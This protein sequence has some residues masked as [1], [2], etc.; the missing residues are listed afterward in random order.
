MC[1][2]KHPCIYAE[3]SIAQSRITLRAVEQY[4]GLGAWSS[5]GQTGTAWHLRSCNVLIMERDGG[6]SFEQ[7]TRRLDLPCLQPVELHYSPLQ[8]QFFNCRVLLIN[9]FFITVGWKSVRIL[10]AVKS[11][12]AQLW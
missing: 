10:R 1:W 5:G 11:E 8:F 4:A 2:E 6:R 3:M 7:R 9:I 12:C